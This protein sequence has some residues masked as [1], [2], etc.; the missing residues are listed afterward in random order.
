MSVVIT[1]DRTP[2]VDVPETTKKA[3]EKICTEIFSPFFSDL[4]IGW[5]HMN[6][7]TGPEIL[8]IKNGY[9]G[10]MEYMI[11]FLDPETIQFEGTYKPFRAKAKS[12]EGLKVGLKEMLAMEKLQEEFCQK[13]FP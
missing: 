3:I 5:G 10:R 2:K 9:Y 7:V 6:S 1:E 4:R 12:V 8:S 13:V 11:R